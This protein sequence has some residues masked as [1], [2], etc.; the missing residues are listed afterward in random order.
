MQAY[1]HIWPNKTPQSICSNSHAQD[2]LA[3]R[4][5]RLSLVWFQTSPKK[6]VI[7]Y[8]NVYQSTEICHTEQLI[9]LIGVAGNWSAHFSYENHELQQTAVWIIYGG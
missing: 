8:V 1:T 6:S 3:L 2:S 4:S 9:F 5:L 7:E